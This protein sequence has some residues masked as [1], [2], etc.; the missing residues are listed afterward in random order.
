MSAC[1]SALTSCETSYVAV[2]RRPSAALLL[3]CV[4]PELLPNPE[5]VS[6][7]EINVERINVARAF[8][9]CKQRHADLAKFVTALRLSATHYADL[10]AVL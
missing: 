5:S 7:E 4:D 9:D 2:D 3:P 6:S 8:V 1:A 10:K